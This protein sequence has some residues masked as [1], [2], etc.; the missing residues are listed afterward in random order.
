MIGWF[1]VF[2]STFSTTRLYYNV[3]DWE[4]IHS[5]IRKLYKHAPK[6]NN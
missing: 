4:Q 5:K 3:E 2:M 1:V 6:Y